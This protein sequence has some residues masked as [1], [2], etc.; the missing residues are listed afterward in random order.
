[1]KTSKNNAKFARLIEILPAPLSDIEKIL[2]IL[3]QHKITS[4][5][6]IIRR[7]FDNYPSFLR[8][9]SIEI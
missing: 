9:T 5:K 6:H 7:K 4:K 2:F 8:K 1:M 3:K